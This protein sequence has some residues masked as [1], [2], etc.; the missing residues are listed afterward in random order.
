MEF[1]IEYKDDHEYATWT[2]TADDKETAIIT[3]CGIL[4]KNRMQTEQVI[5]SDFKIV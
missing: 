5:P 2:I 3:L 1:K 4:N